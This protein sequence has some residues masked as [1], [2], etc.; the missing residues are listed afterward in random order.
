M[1]SSDL[2]GGAT[3]APPPTP[4]AHHDNIMSSSDAADALSR[5][6]QRLPPTLS[7]PTRLPSPSSAAATCPPCLSLNDVLS[8]VSKLG[9]AQ[10]TDHSVPSELANS[11]ESEALALFD[12]SQD[13]KQSLF[14]KNWPLGYGND[15][16]EDEDGVADSFRFDSACST[17]SSEL[18][19]FSLRKFARELE[20]LGLM[21]VD[22][23]TKD[24]GCE[25]PLGDD[26][27]RVCSVMWVSESLPGNKSGGFYP[28]V[29]GL[30]YQI[31]NQKYSLLSDSGWVSVLPHVDSILVTFGDIAQVW[32]NGKLKKV[33]GRPMATVGDENGSRCIT[34]SLL[35]TLPTDSRVAPLLPKVTCN[36]DQKEEEIEGEEEE[37]NDGGDEELE[38]RVFNSFDFEDY[39]WRVYHERI[40]FKDPLD[41]YRVV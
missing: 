33:R 30:Q 22:E 34:M 13:Q 28:F 38:K 3:S 5:L 32:S 23:L 24:L 12:L 9:Y 18:A 25:N 41:R 40:L 10:L 36:K 11:A 17:E 14:P 7:L 21:I 19:L 26:P 4:A 29:I 31:R 6:L 1:A 15:E 27:T 35:I 39:A 2:F 8:C 37:N 16:D 20:K